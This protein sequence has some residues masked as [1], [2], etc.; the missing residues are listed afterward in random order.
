MLI[1]DNARTLGVGVFPWLL[2]DY[3]LTYSDPRFR[4]TDEAIPLAP[5]LLMNGGLAAYPAQNL[6]AALGGRFLDDRAANEDRSVIA[7]GYPLI[8]LLLC[9]RWR[10]IDVFNLAGTDWRETQFATESC[11]RRELGRDSRCPRGGGGPGILDTNVVS[12]YGINIRGGL[13]MFF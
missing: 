8:D 2:L 4:V 6:S 12:G 10:N 5:T 11:L 3:D 9:H 13:T 1:Y 7:R